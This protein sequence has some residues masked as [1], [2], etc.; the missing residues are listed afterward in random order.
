MNSGR[1][2]LTSTR[3]FRAKLSLTAK[4]RIPALYYHHPIVRL[5]VVG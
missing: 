5:T 4:P 1:E 2:K 3:P